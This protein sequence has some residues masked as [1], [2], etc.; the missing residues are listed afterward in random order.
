MLVSGEIHYFRVAREQWEQ[1]LDLA[2]DTGLTTVASYLPW[3]FHERPDGTVDVE[4]RTRPERDVGA[5]IDLCAQRGL[6]FLARPGPF[7]MA[8]LK[9]EG[10]P[11]RLYD[12]HPEIVPRG[13]D[14]RPAPSR[15]LDYL[16]PAFLAET[17]RWY[18]AIL[19]IL[20]PRLE[21]NGGNVIGV[22]LDNEVGMLAWVT[23]SPD[24]TDDVLADFARWVETSGRE[25]AYP[26]TPGGPHWASAVRSPHPDY[27]GALRL[28]LAYFMRDRF[29]RYIRALRAMAVERGITGVP[30]FVNLHGTESGSG[31]P[32][33]I[34][35]SQLVSTYAG[36]PG[37]I[38]GSDH[39]LGEPTLA[40]MVDLHMMNA[41]MDAAEP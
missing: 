35:I 40:T 17:A 22:Q 32:F 41:F 38:A 8:E 1:R 2:V 4:G 16:A 30:F 25:S 21:P 34:G 36:V 29:A 23:N 12:E 3:V 19:P 13:W 33:P 7:V 10:V 14:G 11:F 15:T 20:R 31:A 18:D 26:L 39:Y 27:A 28:D 37:L 24:L 5:F 6:T 9:N